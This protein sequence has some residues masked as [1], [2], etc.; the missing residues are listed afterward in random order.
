MSIRLRLLLGGFVL[1]L[2]VTSS[3]FLNERT[4]DLENL[5]ASNPMGIGS[6][7]DPNARMHYEMMRLVNP[8][9]GEI[10]AG[11]RSR[12]LKFAKSLPVKQEEKSLSWVHRGPTNK[13][14]RTRA[15]AFDVRDENV[16][17][18]GGVTGGMWKTEDG[19]A[20]W[21]KTTDPDQ[22]HSVTS[23]A[24][25]KRNGMEDTWYYGTGE[26]YGIV[27]GTSFTSRFSGDGIFKSTDG[28]QTWSQLT[29]TASGSPETLYDSGDFD[30]VWRIVTDHTNTAEDVV[31]AAVYD[32]IFRSNDG[33]TTWTS[34]L[35]LQQNNNAASAFADVVISDAGILYAALSSGGAEKGYWR[36]DD[37]GLTWA[38]IMPSSHP[39]SYRRTAI[40][41]NPANENEVYFLTETP[42][43][44]V[45]G[46]SLYQ[47]TYLSGDGTGAGG[48]WEDR[49]ANLPNE[50][51]TGYFTFNFGPFNSQSSYNLCMTMH[52]NGN[53]LY[54]G[55]TNIYR[56]TDNFST[57]TN[58]T[59]I[60]G[61]RCDTIDPSNYVYPNHHPDNHVMLFSDANP[62]VMYS[63]SDGG[64]ARCDDILATEVEWTSLNNGYFTTQFYTVE[65]EQGNAT[66]D[67][68]IGGMQDNGTWFTNSEN[69][70]TLWKEVGID[71]GAYCA[72]PEGRNFYVISSQLGRMYKKEV[73]DDGNIL[74]TN[75]MDPTGG[76]SNYNFINQFILDPHNNNRLY[77]AARNRIWMNSDV[78]G[79]ALNN[80]IYNTVATNWNNLS[81]SQIAISAGVV[82]CL[83][84]SAA[85][86]DVLLYGTSAA[87]LYRL[88]S[89]STNPVQTEITSSEF[90]NGA[91]MSCIAPNPHD[92]D[93][94]MVTFA[95]YE[96]RSIFHSTDQGTTWTSVGGNLEEFADGSGSGPAVYWALVY[97]TYPSPTYF[98][99]TSIG[100]LST[101]ELDG[102]NTV[103]SMEGP[104]SIGNVVINM[105]RART[106][107]G[108]IA[109]ATHGAGIYSSTLPAAF[110]GQKEEQQ[111]A[112]AVQY[113]PNPFVDQVHLEFLL[114]EAGEVSLEIMD[115]NGRVVH[116]QNATQLPAGKHTLV[117]QPN[118]ASVAE[119][120]YVYQL[121]IDGKVQSGKMI[122]SA[123]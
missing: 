83:E 105:I 77:L 63:G 79:I 1:S 5:N 33:G 94:W 21:V 102:D 80:D 114:E 68:I 40:A 16:L 99:G 115:L 82:T 103:W 39:T 6:A 31:L 122:R 107:D 53:S 70:D 10:P 48:Q 88:D 95:N 75:R 28:G 113:Y 41:I 106:Y 59:W 52:P 110:V 118:T 72:I 25:D 60:G 29:S 69:I 64:V 45:T 9:T 49:T 4:S 42:G 15:L 58:T 23:L 11:I 86:P 7:E 62:D 13:G 65:M 98:V 112:V 121:M 78:T 44:G 97:P 2:G 123:Q 61:Y 90:P 32:G 46:H 117:W 51:C 36:S 43:S 20:T 38:N 109:I 120:V 67:I 47:Y 66:S 26:F 3:F 111:P 55:G 74:A 73:D 57:D 27:S 100:L 54:I 92:A 35:G 108:T 85:L 104:T 30:F 14:G 56:S 93:E 50:D 34:V 19:G 84:I 81:A 12:E 101:N 116:Q 91:Y 119:G 96:V 37:G 87:R 17:L 18:A 71:D 22:I 89:A 76:P 24:Q 8:E